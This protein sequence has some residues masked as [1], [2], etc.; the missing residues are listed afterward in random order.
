MSNGSAPAYAP[1]PTFMDLA[2]PVRGDAA[3]TAVRGAI[4]ALLGT[5]LL[6]VSAK[7]QVPFWPVPMTL[8]SMVVLL[9]GAAYGWR[10]GA[11]TLMLY[12]AEGAIGLP[13]FA[14]TPE[15]GIGLAYMMGPTG[16][17]L[18]GFAL[19][20]A[21][22]GYLAERGWDRSLPRVVAL[23][24]LGHIVLFL[25]GLAWLAAIMGWEQAWAVGVAPF[26]AG[27]V[28]KTALA[29]ALAQAGWTFLRRARG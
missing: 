4:L 20:A 12:L 28:V 9:I 11:A 13:V 29:V 27:T 25:P 1:A 5:A 16:G 21:A 17:F 2:W 23:M 7:I 14:G 26:V 19:A 24:I 15:R 8:Q 18:I 22:T 6:I 10:L 3:A